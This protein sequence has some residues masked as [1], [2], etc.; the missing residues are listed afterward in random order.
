MTRDQLARRIEEVSPAGFAALALDVFRYQ[1]ANNQIYAQYLEL[2]RV[3]PRTVGRR[4]DIPHLPIALFKSQQ[5]RSGDWQP[6]RTFTSS[7][8]TGA[9]TSRHDLRD[10][11]WYRRGA[12]L[13]F[14]RQYG[15][16]AG[17]AV[18]A[19]LP[20]YLERSGS[21]LVFMAQDF[22]ERS[23]HPDSGFFLD[24]LPGLADRLA[25][26]REQRIP[27]LLLGVSF[28]LLELGERFPQPLGNTIVMETGGMKGRRR[29][30]TRRELH[31]TLSAAFSVPH[32]HSEYGMTELLSQAYAPADGRFH[33]APTLSVT[34]RDITDPLAPA[35]RGR[36]AALNLT[37]LANLDTVSFIASDDLGRV[38][39]DDTF[40]VL[41][42]LDHSDVRG[43]NLLVGALS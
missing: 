34:P 2:L 28:A 32:I 42:R 12:A 18:L 7:G 39:A 15:P 5:L 27:T 4:T 26:L 23:G 33:P 30:M 25:R 37:D 24:D 35:P 21:S 29:E 31:A 19:L 6:V 13:T 3:D 8:T 1:A 16:L 17:R 9:A 40:E 14:E 20:A 11:D 41:G 36:T 10:A 38:F 43:C 22:I